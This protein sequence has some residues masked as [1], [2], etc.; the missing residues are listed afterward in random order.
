MTTEDELRGLVELKREGPTLD[1]KQDLNLGSESENAEFIKDT[2][3]LANSGLT[4]YI[5]TG[6]QDRTWEP[7]GITESHSQVRLNQILQNRTDPP[8]SVEYAEIELNGHKHGVVKILGE[9]PP[10]LVMV[11]DS[12]GGIQRGRVFIRNV[13]MN[14]GA[15][16]VDLDKLYSKVDLRLS[17]EVKERKVTDDSTEVNIEFT[18]SNVG[19]VSG[20]FVRV[21]VRF[22]NIRQIVKR[23]GAWQD[24]SY[25]RKNV[26]TIQMDENIV[27]LN[28]TLHCDGAVVQVSKGVKQIEAYIT[29]YAMNMVPKRG[30]YV[31]PLES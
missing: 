6:I 19:H 28:E 9:N 16:R 23:T 3:A 18:L 10:Y 7:V 31:I 11:K 12:Y 30:E 1:Y 4:A 26:P 13:D 2:L 5:V 27:H 24:I 25:L 22:K 15:R 20:A 14:E 29:L 21:T 17:H 8:I